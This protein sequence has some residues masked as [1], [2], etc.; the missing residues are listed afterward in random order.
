LADLRVLT[1]D[2]TASVAR[3]YRK[4]ITASRRNTFFLQSSLDQLEIL[5]MLDMR[6]EYVKTGVQTLTEEI[7]RVGKD[8]VE[9]VKKGKKSAPKPQGQAFLFEGYMVDY[10]DK[11]YMAF[12]KEKETQVRAEIAKRLDKFNANENDRAFT[13]GLSAGSEIIFAELCAERGVRVDAH[14]ALPDTA[15]IREFVSPGG[16]EWVERFY[17]IR[18]HPLVDEYYQ[19]ENLGQPKEG[20]DLYE[21]NNRW[22][23]YSSLRRGIDK[24]RLIVLWDGKGTKRADLDARLVKHMVDLMREIGGQVEHINSAKFMHAN[25]MDNTYKSPSAVDEPSPRTKPKTVKTPHQKK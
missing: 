19:H 2:N 1:A 20:D 6:D 13:A 15:Y 5:K 11:G 14:F 7:S 24:V 18:N 9:P 16:D 22:A 25:Y 3:A 8:A 21:R 12:P 17:K 23:L 4:A 10:P